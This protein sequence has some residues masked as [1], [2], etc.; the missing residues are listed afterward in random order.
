MHHMLC[1]CISHGGG[2]SGPG[3][4]LLTPPPVPF[5]APCLHLKVLQRG[6]GSSSH[7]RHPFQQ[8]FLWLITEKSITSD[9]QQRFFL[10]ILSCVL[11]L[12]TY[13][14]L[15]F[16]GNW[17]PHFT[18]HWWPAQLHAL[19]QGL[20]QRHFWSCR[21]VLPRLQVPQGGCREPEQCWD[22]VSCMNKPSLVSC[23]ELQGRAAP[24]ACQKFLRPHYLWHL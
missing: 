2:P 4:A 15:L 11:S 14:W 3:T 13:R 6:A 16:L 10:L 5:S 21:W 20:E 1:P 12:Q 7:S 22:L 23:S 8:Q 18:G 24:Q 9:L 19:T 17:N